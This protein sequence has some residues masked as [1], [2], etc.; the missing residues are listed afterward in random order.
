M[1][2]IQA[3]EWTIILIGRHGLA[4]LRVKVGCP[5]EMG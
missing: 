3:L 1:V 2:L 5:L 4:D